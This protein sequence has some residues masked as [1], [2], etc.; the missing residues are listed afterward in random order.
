MGLYV[1]DDGDL[2]TV[3]AQTKHLVVSSVHVLAW[4]SSLFVVVHPGVAHFKSVQY[5]TCC[6]IFTVCAQAG[7][8]HFPP[9]FLV[10]YNCCRYSAAF[11]DLARY[12]LTDFSFFG[13]D[14]LSEDIDLPRGMEPTTILPLSLISCCDILF[15]SFRFKSFSSI[16]YSSESQIA[17]D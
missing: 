5:S 3:I 2:I 9:H 6:S 13:I 8:E 12:S 11:L 17:S 16:R 10:W 14:A 1:T 15:T 4:L 7:E